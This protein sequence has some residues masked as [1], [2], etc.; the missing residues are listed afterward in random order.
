MNVMI[1]MNVI[2]YIYMRIPHQSPRDRKITLEREDNKLTRLGTL[3]SKRV[4]FWTALLEF[5]P[6]QKRGAQS[7]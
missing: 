5:W 2:L 4:A 7:T 6:P 1:L 3:T